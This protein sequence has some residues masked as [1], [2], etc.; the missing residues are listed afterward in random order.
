MG[1][2]RGQ[3][4]ADLTSC[5]IDCRA[6]LSAGRRRRDEALRADR[7]GFVDRAPVIVERGASSCRVGGGKHAAAAQAGDGHCVR[8]DELRRT[9][10]AAGLHDVAAK[11]RSRRCRRG[12]SP[13]PAQQATMASPSSN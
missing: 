5:V 9:L 2:E 6:S 1:Q 11:A 13:R 7:G 12:R 3:G 8:A 4:V 10:D